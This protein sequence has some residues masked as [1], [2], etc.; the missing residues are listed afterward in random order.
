VIRLS[1]ISDYGIVVMAH[2][3]EQ[4]P[5]SRHS[6]RGIAAATRL[7]APVVSKILKALTRAGLL[8]SQRGPHGGYSLARPP[9]SITLAD[10]IGALDGPFGLTECTMHPGQCAQE[11]SCHVRQPWQQINLV[12]RK[13]LADV[14]LAKLALL[15]GPS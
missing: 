5:G 4:A 3:A 1:R 10:M 7:P 12:V 2:L 6:A 8:A 14:T 11:K 15:G 9:E 13:A